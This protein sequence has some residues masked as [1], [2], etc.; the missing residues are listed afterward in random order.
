L[1]ETIISGGIAFI[2][3]YL[4]GKL[5]DSVFQFKTDAHLVFLGEPLPKDFFL[6]TLFAMFIGVFIQLT[7]EEKPM[8]ESF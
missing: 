2:Y 5:I 3:S 1:A 7:F 4:I 8:T 6:Y